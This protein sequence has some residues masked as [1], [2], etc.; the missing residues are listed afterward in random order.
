M[1]RLEDLLPELAGVFAAQESALENAVAIL[2][3]QVHRLVL[4]GD[5]QSRKIEVLELTQHSL[6]DSL[7]AL[8]TKHVALQQKHDGLQT[9]HAAAA[10][11][12]QR[13]LQQSEQQMKHTMATQMEQQV[14][15]LATQQLQAMEDSLSSR[16]EERLLESSHRTYLQAQQTEEAMQ[17]QLELLEKK[18]EYLSR[19]KMEIKDLSKKID[20]HDQTMGDMRIGLE[21]LAKSIGTDDSDSDDDNDA[22][23]QQLRE[24]VARTMELDSEKQQ[25]LDRLQLVTPQRSFRVR[26]NRSRNASA[27][28]TVVKALIEQ[29]GVPQATVDLM[30]IDTVVLEPLDLSA[31]FSRTST[32]DDVAPSSSGTP[33]GSR[34]GSELVPVP[35]EMAT[36]DA[37]EPEIIVD[38]PT[39]ELKEEVVDTEP[40]ESPRPVVDEEAPVMSTE[41]LE[42]APEP[43]P[44][45]PM[46]DEEPSEQVTQQ[47]SP[48]I[49]ALAFAPSPEEDHP[50]QQDEEFTSQASTARSHHH[51]EDPDEAN[52]QVP[53]DLPKGS[54][55]RVLAQ[56]KQLDEHVSLL[57]SSTLSHAAPSLLHSATATAIIRTRRQVRS[58]KRTNSIRKD[59]GELSS[60]RESMIQRE[61]MT[62]EQMKVMWRRVFMRFVQLK[63]LQLL[64]GTSVD[65]AFF[66]KQN[67]SV[68][69]RVKRLD[70]TVVDLEEAME[71]LENDIRNNS[72]NVQALDQIITHNQI[73]MDL[74]TKQLDKAQAD[75]AKRIVGL[76]EKLDNMETEV[77]RLRTAGNRRDSSVSANTASAIVS[78][79]TSF[80]EMHARVAQHGTALQ[81]AESTIKKLCDVDLPSMKDKT[82]RSIDNVRTEMQLKTNEL[83]KDIGKSLQKLQTAHESS[84][85]LILSQT[86]G[87]I[88]RMYR[89]LLMISHALLSA[90]DMMKYA[91]GKSRMPVDV[92]LDLFE[93]IY[94]GYEAPDTEVTANENEEDPL[95]VFI[96]KNVQFKHELAKLK[97][98]SAKAKAMA[99]TTESS[100][101]NSSIAM[102]LVYVATAQLRALEDLA[103]VMSSPTDSS[104]TTGE[105]EL[106]F[107]A[108]DLIVQMRTVLFLFFLHSQLLNPMHSIQA[109]QTVQSEMQE[110]LK[111]H[112]FAIVQAD[113]LGAVVKLMN[114]RVDSLIE[115][116]FSFAK[117]ADVKNS[118]QEILN[119]SSDARSS[120]AKQVE[121]T[122]AETTARNER[123]EK[124]L[125]QL[126]G[127]VSKKLDKDELLWTQEVLE[128]QVQ[129]VAKSS[130]GEEDLMDL[131]RM[132]RSKMD[133]VHFE[134]L[135]QE[136]QRANLLAGGAGGPGVLMGPDG[137]PRGVP[138]VGSKCISCQN[139]EPPTKAMIKS[140]VKAEVQQEIARI[141]AKQPLHNAAGAPVVASAAAFNVSAHRSMEKYKK[142]MLLAAMQQQQTKSVRKA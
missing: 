39:E 24:P 138:L 94:A 103:Q 45:A 88:E 46:E 32:F 26:G 93:Q 76:E 113:S 67:V 57:R 115:L 111:T 120:L 50:Q 139:E 5:Q 37:P 3:T 91:K 90:V 47:E 104:M 114:T 133:R 33:A 19:V 79:E 84:Q 16:L 49:E 59:S 87:S 95:A 17:T 4:E 68:G 7:A 112:G 102:H 61:P 20:K 82:D 135:M 118:I 86:S 12:T 6:Q 30:P 35:V 128:R 100:G 10:E 141:L 142:E 75:H 25:A 44:V 2:T 109:M 69:A 53:E 78:L 119:A 134:A 63:R 108:R 66:R 80:L 70:E 14:K 125:M 137:V 132:L 117:D 107:R 22:D 64:N 98:Q 81:T 15:S 71:L 83:A 77:H 101:D 127:R 106:V 21:I 123:L 34:R 140:A 99:A 41:E 18:F 74:K 9:Q 40:Q 129:N 13:Q 23:Q 105:V 55:S 29:S 51:D 73:V 58:V 52:D 122:T 96:S 72:H 89:D 27:A 116:T 48:V 85:E 121:T 43:A 42:T 62:R 56:Q 130:L 38:P 54:K 60:R 28:D 126:A 136:Q 1:S 36:L 31:A 110:E 8:Q 11:N 131:H 97:D 124:E 65:K 92:G